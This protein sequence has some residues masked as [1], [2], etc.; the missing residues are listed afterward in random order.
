MRGTVCRGP[1]WQ[2]GW[3]APVCGAGD[4]GFFGE[5]SL[6]FRTFQLS[7]PILGCSTVGFHGMTLNNQ[8]YSNHFHRFCGE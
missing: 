3:A 4:A 6:Q 7:G 2:G 1:R 8:L 5:M